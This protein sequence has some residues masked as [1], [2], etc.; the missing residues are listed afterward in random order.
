MQV[1]IIIGT[2]AFMLTMVII[3]FISLREPARLDA[4]TD[5]YAGRSVENGA[6]IF[7]DNCATCHGVNGRAE[8]CFDPASGEQIGCQGLPLN[9]AQLVC[10]A[11]SPRMEAMGWAGSKHSFIQSTISAGRPWNGM[12]TW[13]EQYGGP[14]QG[15]QVEDVTL[16]VLNWENEELC[17]EPAEGVADEWPVV[18]A[19]LPEGDPDSGQELYAVTFGCQACHGDP[20]GDASTAT[21]GPWLGNIAEEGAERRDGYTAADYVYESILH[22]NAFIAPD[23]PTG[24]CSE[25]SQMPPD[26]GARM[27]QQDMADVMAY[28]LG[29]GQFESNTEIE[30][31]E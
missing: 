23:C 22:P 21:L 25:P 24:P 27:E 5:A 7:F 19:D 15:N 20:A 12:P 29:T 1:K 10:G 17:E 26:F 31:P 3:G 6:E 28:M 16:F 13:G 8:E 11:T 30:L 18:V 2:I 9:N 14:L 4:F